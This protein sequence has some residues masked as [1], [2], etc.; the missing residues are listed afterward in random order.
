MCLS[1]RVV[2]LCEGKEGVSCT[3]GTANESLGCTLVKEEIQRHHY[4]HIRAPNTCAS[5][6][7]EIGY[8]DP[9]Q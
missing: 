5:D 1:V 7:Y 6:V 2:L 3:S 8:G 9:N 4:E